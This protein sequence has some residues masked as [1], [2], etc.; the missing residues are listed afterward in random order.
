MVELVIH[1]FSQSAAITSRFDADALNL[2]LGDV[3]FKTRQQATLTLA[4]LQAMFTFSLP[5]SVDSTTSYAK[6]LAIAPVA[7]GIT[8]TAINSSKDVFNDFMNGMAEKF[9]GDSAASGLFL[10]KDELLVAYNTL[11]RTTLPAA[12]EA[13]TSITATEQA[14]KG[15]LYKASERFDLKYNFTSFDLVAGTY[16]HAVAVGGTSSASAVVHVTSAGTGVALT[17]VTF[18]SITSGTFVKGETVTITAANTQTASAAINDVQRA[19]LNGTFDGHKHLIAGATVTSGFQHAGI[20]KK[21]SVVSSVNAAATAEV[22]VHVNVAGDITAIYV[23]TTDT[24]SNFAST[25]AT[26]TIS[27]DNN[28]ITVPQTAD[29]NTYLNVTSVGTLHNSIME[30]TTAAPA[31]TAG[32]TTVKEFADCILTSTSGDGAARATVHIDGT[33]IKDIYITTPGSG[34]VAAEVVTIT[35]GTNTITFTPA[36]NDAALTFIDGTITG[37]DALTTGAAI[38]GGFTNVASF[39]DCVVTAVGGAVNTG[40]AVVDVHIA[41]N[42]VITNIYWKSASFQTFVN[43]NS[44]TTIVHGSNIITLDLSS[45]TAADI[46]YLNT[47]V[48]VVTLTECP[49]ETQDKILCVFTANSHASQKA[50]DDSTDISYAQSFPVAISD[51]FA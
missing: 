19:R 41:S 20:Y 12:V 44:T 25:V 38:T 21:C 9:F 33:G 30:A 34:Y 35:I 28:T 6:I 8:W 42:G 26:L 24:A 48:E 51:S 5:T 11:V 1:P 50:N 13:V 47:G 18:V 31:I 7:G 10:G 23:S 32:F 27:L 40:R 16:R 39:T 15:L 45:V 22:S 36:A 49:L 29:T 3:T 43:N 46:I 14:V 37:L 2:E 17:D 4:Q